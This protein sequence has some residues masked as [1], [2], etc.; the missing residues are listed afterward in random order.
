MA[1]SPKEE[2]RYN[3]KAERYRAEREER[4]EAL[5][6]KDGS[7]KAVAKNNKMRN[8]IWSAVAGVILV[9]AILW[10]I[11]WQTGVLHRNLPALNVNGQ[12]VSIN[13]Y[14]F[15]YFNLYDS[16]NR[17]YGDGGLLDLRANSKAFTGQDKTWGE[18]FEDEATLQS[19]SSVLTYQAALD[20]G[21]EL[22]E[23]DKAAV[24]S[25][26]QMMQSSIGTPVD[27]E[28]YLSSMFG[29]GM[30][31][32]AY[33][34]LMS[35]D[36]LAA[37]YVQ[38]YPYTLEVS[39]SEIEEHYED[40]SIK[41]STVTYHSFLVKT[42]TTNEDGEDFTTEELAEAKEETKALAEEMLEEINTAEDVI[43]VARENASTE[44]DK[45]AYEDEDSTL[46]QAERRAV[47]SA[48]NSRA[49]TWLF[50]EDRETGD[51]EIVES[52]NNFEIIYLVSIDKDTRKTAD[53]RVA[54]FNLTDP[55]GDRVD[56]Q[57]IEQ[58]RDAADLMQRT[59]KSDEDFINY[60]KQDEEDTD[61]AKASTSVLYEGLT[62]STSLGLHNDVRSWA[63]SDDTNTGD[64]VML[65]T[66]NF[67]YVAHLVEKHDQASYA[68]DIEVVLQEE[69]FIEQYN[70]ALD[71]PANDANQI[72][73]GWWFVG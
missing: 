62:G 50:D 4:L 66:D 33:S 8:I 46:H 65:E 7:K 5:R 42:P 6:N 3:T 70:D 24:N 1:R 11:L 43:N 17:E 32:N 30:S 67:I 15:A 53:V 64:T 55:E 40:N 71:D 27:F 9:F 57:V 37:S 41:Y 12:N 28:M 45:A 22:S 59:I 21:Y 36:Y 68:A 26:I 63:L 61:K 47:V 20:A 48:R 23:E 54:Y 39:D 58:Y 13:E 2:K 44:E 72:Y 31:L 18:F 49:A 25:Y 56:D 38:E 10:L 73:P 29:K 60:D 51:K 52:G 69:K 34:D 14:N 35:K 16:Y 19:K